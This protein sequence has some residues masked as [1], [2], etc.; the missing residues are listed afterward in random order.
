MRQAK[1]NEKHLMKP[2][3]LSNHLLLN[4]WKLH[5]NNFRYPGGDHL[6]SNHLEARTKIVLNRNNTRENK[7]SD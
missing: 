3:R 2:K 5:H 6:H 1:Q 7:P 4:E